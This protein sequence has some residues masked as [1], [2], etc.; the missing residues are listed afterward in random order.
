MWSVLRRGMGSNDSNLR[1]NLGL[2]FFLSI[3]VVRFVL[4]A[5]LIRNSC[6]MYNDESKALDLFAY[7]EV[8]E[9]HIFFRL[10]ALVAGSGLHGAR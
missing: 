6:L 2:L 10:Q 4:T 3:C 8:Q 7:F 9:S 5:D 1:S